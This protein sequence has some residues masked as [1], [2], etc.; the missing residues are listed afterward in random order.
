MPNNQL[1]LP[2][3]FNP[4][5]W[6]GPDG[7][8]N[9]EFWGALLVGGSIIGLVLYFWSI[10]LPW[11]LSMMVD[12]LHLTFLIGLFISILYLVLGKRPRM[13][14][15]VLIRRM[16]SVFIATYPIQ[17]IQEQ[18]SKMKKKRAK[19]N[20]H[21][22]RL[23]AAIRQVKDVMAQN[24]KEA[25]E[26]MGQALQAKKMASAAKDQDEQLRMELQM[27]RNARRAERRNQS[28]IGFSELL[29]K[30]QKIYSTLSR[31]ATNLDFFI[32]DTEDDIKQKRIEYET[33]QNA[34]GAIKAAISMLSG[35]SAVEEEMYSEAYY[36]IQKQVS[37]QLGY[38]DDFQ[39][40]SQNFMD[41]MD[42]KT[43]AVDD[44]ALKQ[45]EEFE[46]KLLTSGDKS[47][48]M[49]TMDKSSKQEPVLIPRVA[50]GS[51]DLS[52]LL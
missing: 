47:L 35:D 7:K 29:K 40:L 18:L 33:S 41:G 31:Y 45:M 51:N 4:M 36:Q 22:T 6:R 26:G 14:F 1:A 42:V 38:M 5:S 21:M 37:E 10:L 16:T 23:S 27:K 44:A 39:R 32:E 43:G 34:G 12:T 11:L 17:I 24:A 52:D 19:F 46:H 8:L 13:M 20:G 9:R 30:L 28:N 48:E 49:F 15:H 3:N 50:S 25:Q 2:D